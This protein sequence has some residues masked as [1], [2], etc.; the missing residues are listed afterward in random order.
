[1]IFYNAPSD[2]NWYSFIE[3]DEFVPP[4]TWYVGKL[5]GEEEAKETNQTS[6]YSISYMDTSFYINATNITG[7][8]ELSGYIYELKLNSDPIVDVTSRPVVL[9]FNITTDTP[10]SGIVCLYFDL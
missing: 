10:P 1:L 4:G 3:L 6:D 9:S 7:T 8:L 5:V 2:N